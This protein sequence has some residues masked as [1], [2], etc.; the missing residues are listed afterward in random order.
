MHTS[1]EGGSERSQRAAQSRLA[2][3]VVRRP[4]ERHHPG[5][6]HLRGGGPERLQGCVDRVVARPAVDAR[7]DQREGDRLRTQLVGD[8]E[9]P[10][11][12]GRQQRAVPLAGVVVGPDH[13]DHPARGH[14]P[15]GRPA[16]VTGREPVGEASYAVLEH[17]LAAGRMDRS[18]D[19]SATS[20]PVVRRVDHRVQV[21]LGDVAVDDLDLHGPEPATPPVRQPMSRSTARSSAAWRWSA[22][23]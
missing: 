14:L 11:V 12:A 15:G 1:E 13:V 23:S 18:V 8:L 9:R 3:P 5:H 22:S 2:D 20:H 21:L 4:A 16:G 7:T 10:A 17:G 6:L 19:S